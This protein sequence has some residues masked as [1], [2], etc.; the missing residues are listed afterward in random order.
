MRYG[1][2]VTI[3]STDL[4]GICDIPSIQSALKITLSLSLPFSNGSA[5]PPP[6]LGNFVHAS[7]HTKILEQ[8]QDEVSNRPA[9]RLQ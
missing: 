9:H 2:S 7:L 5:C 6:S 8:V 1:G 4:A 3:K